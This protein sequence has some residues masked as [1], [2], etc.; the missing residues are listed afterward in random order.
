L[1]RARPHLFRGYRPV[2]ATGPTSD[3]VL[4]FERA[5]AVAVGTRLPVRLAQ[6][7]GFGETFLAL[8]GAYTDVLTAERHIGPIRLTQLLRRYPVAL[9]VRA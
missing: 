8:E 4:A 5:G 3:H 2:A 1:R 6:S 9:L 7:G